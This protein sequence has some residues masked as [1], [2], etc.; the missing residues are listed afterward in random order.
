MSEIQFPPPYDYP[1]LGK[2]DFF[3]CYIANPPIL[4]GSGSKICTAVVEE[5]DRRE[6][7]HDG[8]GWDK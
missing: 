6:I 1:K 4:K 7:S 2:D 3:F 8:Q 5:R